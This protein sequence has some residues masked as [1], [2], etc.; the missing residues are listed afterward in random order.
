MT[1]LPE[2]DP[3]VRV[4]HRTGRGRAGV[5]GIEIV[6]QHVHATRRPGGIRDRSCPELVDARADH[7]EPRSGAQ[8]RIPHGTVGV[9]RDR[10]LLEAEGPH[11]ELQRLV[12]V[13]VVQVRNDPAC[14]STSSSRAL[15]PG[16]PSA[17][18]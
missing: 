11:Q 15:A 13:R 9:P 7:D 5:V 10:V 4:D 12:G 8:L 16:F 2:V 6:D 17:T 3:H 14:G 1:Y 18:R